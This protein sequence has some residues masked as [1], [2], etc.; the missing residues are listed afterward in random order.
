M[1]AS[2]HPPTT[3]SIHPFLL[4]HIP[5]WPN[6]GPKRNRLARHDGGRSQRCVVAATVLIVKRNVCRTLRTSGGHRAERRI[7]RTSVEGF[8]ESVAHLE[9]EAMVEAHCSCNSRMLMRSRAIV[10]P[11]DADL[12][13]TWSGLIAVDRKHLD[14]SPGG[15][16]QSEITRC[17]SSSATPPLSR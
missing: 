14:G 5:P 17:P 3:R 7:K 11:R 4:S 10:M 13:A 15:Q 9:L 8:R 16:P 1:P 12:Q 2:D 6:V